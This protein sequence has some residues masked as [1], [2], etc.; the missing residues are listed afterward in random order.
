MSNDSENEIKD[1]SR[2]WIKDQ[3]DYFS[4]KVSDNIRMFAIAFAGVCWGVVVSKDF[5]SLL[6]DNL[7]FSLIISLFFFV[8]SLIF[9][10]LHYLSGTLHYRPFAAKRD[11]ASLKKIPYKRNLL[12]EGIKLFNLLKQFMFFFGML[13]FTPSIINLLYISIEKLF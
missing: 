1:V 12:F 2:A 9:D 5:A 11:D 10:Y 7:K 4:S 13:F 6:T 3:S 8:I